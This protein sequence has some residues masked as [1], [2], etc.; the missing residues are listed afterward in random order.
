MLAEPSLIWIEGQESGWACSNCAWKCP[1]PAQP[2]GEEAK[3]AF[4]GIAA[5]RFSEHICGGVAGPS[6]LPPSAQS[7]TDHALVGRARML[8]MRGYKPQDAVE[9]VLRETEL[10]NSNDPRVLAEI[11]AQADDFLLRV[12]QG[13]I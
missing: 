13:L 7:Q 4:H 6:P 10:E 8:I 1:V 3:R 11:R 2:G 12:R 9:L 5:A